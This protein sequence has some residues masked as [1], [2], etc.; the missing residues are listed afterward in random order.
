[1]KIKEITDY[2][3]SLAPLASQESY[4]NCGLIVGDSTTE[5][6][7][8]L[9]T[10]DCIEATVDE[11]IKLGCK[12]IIAHH[13]IIF[14]GLKKLNNKNYIE[15]TV[16]KAIKNDIAIYA[17]HTNFDNYRYGVND[18]IAERLNLINRKIL[19]PK[20]NVLSKVSFFVPLESKDE[21]LSAM[22]LAGAGE[23]GEY[24]E[25]SFQTEGI[26]TFKPSENAHPFE[27][28]RGELSTVK[29][30]KVEVLCSQHMLEAVL[31]AMHQTHPYEEVAHD[32]YSIQ[33]KNQF[34]GSGMIGEVET[35][36][37]ALE[38]LKQLKSTFQC[39]VIRHTELLDK[40]IK[41]VAVCGGSGSF[42]LEQ[43][44]RQKA[45]IFITGDFKYHEFFNSD[46]QI[47]IA[48]IGHF[49]SEQ[50]TSHRLERI[51]IK[52]FTKFAVHLTEEN[53]NPIKYF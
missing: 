39:G 53:T 14:S 43:A 52:K 18:E 28:K 27:G 30:V 15:R 26:G 45:D 16:I 32:I 40:K 41:R 49:E 20:A 31:S 34:E 11:A 13:P 9:I 17:I 51:L 37:D 12:L 21:V 3:E 22:F 23:I 1:M 29:E 50:F 8:V 38:F 7:S 2:L 24:A 48:D 10:L 4:D 5:V 36:M 44:K 19:A 47:V 6:S 33:N 35:E 42:L 46:K 25:C